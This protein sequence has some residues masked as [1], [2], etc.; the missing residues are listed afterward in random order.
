MSLAL[1]AIT[2]ALDWLPRPFEREQDNAS[3][4]LDCAAV[5][6]RDLDWHKALGAYGYCLDAPDSMPA[7]S[8]I[9]A[10]VWNIASQFKR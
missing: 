5:G 6:G 9:S 3:D 7:G 1:R 4:Q 2:L 10:N 8:C